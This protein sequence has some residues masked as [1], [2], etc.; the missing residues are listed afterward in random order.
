MKKN[1]ESSI[2]ISMSDM[3]TGLMLIFLF[4]SIISIVDVR[5]KEKQKNEIVENYKNTKVKIYNDL[6]D[7]FKDDFDNWGISLSKDLTIS[8][9][10]PDLLFEFDSYKV[11][12]KYKNILSSFIPKYFDIINKPEYKDAIQEVRIEGYTSSERE[13]DINSYMYNIDLSQ[14][15]SNSVLSYILKSK[16]FNNLKKEDKEKIRFWFSANGLGYSR[17]VDKSGELVY[18]SKKQQDRKKSRR[19]E[20]RILT[21]SEGLIDKIINQ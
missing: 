8:F 6:K 2:W 9:V 15:R 1:N 14:K 18:F 17:V 4:I 10:N 7:V 20:F 19:V 21:N 13:Y 3:M 16:Y 5:Q 11:K 12:D